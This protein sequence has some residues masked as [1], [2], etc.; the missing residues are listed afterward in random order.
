MGII[1]TRI[2]IFESGGQ[3]IRTVSPSVLDTQMA[4]TLAEKMM[5][6]LHGDHYSI[7]TQKD[8]EYIKFKEGK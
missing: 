3:K 2:T 7:A 4:V 6:K 5:N 8:G 1:K